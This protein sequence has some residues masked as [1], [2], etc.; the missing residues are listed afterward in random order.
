LAD[1]NDAESF[2]HL[3]DQTGETIAAAMRDIVRRKER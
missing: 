3:D 1:E 2:A